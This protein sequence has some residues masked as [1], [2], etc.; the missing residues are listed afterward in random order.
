MEARQNTIVD[1]TNTHRKLRRMLWEIGRRNGALCSAIYF[2]LPLETLLERNAKR[3]KRV[4]D[5]V[6]KK[7]Y[8]TMQS[9]LPYEADLIQ[10]IDK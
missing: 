9:L 5:D 10:I 6:V 3:E 1:A 7:F 4:P 2:D 8:S